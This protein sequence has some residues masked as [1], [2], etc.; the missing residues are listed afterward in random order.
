MYLKVICSWCGKFIRFKEAPG[1][2]QHNQPITHSICPKCKEKL[3]VEIGSIE[4]L[5]H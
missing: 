4:C 3:D 5:N 2:E 1:D